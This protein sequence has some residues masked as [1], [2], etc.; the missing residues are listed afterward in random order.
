MPCGQTHMHSSDFLVTYFRHL[1]KNSL[2]KTIFCHKF[3]G[4]LGK[5]KI[6]T[7]IVTITYNMNACLRFFS[8]IIF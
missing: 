6:V 5:K 7:Q 4:F 2:E 8:T 1:V 3:S